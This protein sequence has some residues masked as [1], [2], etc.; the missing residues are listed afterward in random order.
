MDVAAKKVACLDAMKSQGY[1]GGYAR[2]RIETDD[3]AFGNQ[4]ALPYAECFITLYSPT[5]YYLPVSALDLQKSK[6]SDHDTITLRSYR[7]NVP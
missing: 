5:N 7:V 3:G 2:K 4:V 6:L 1:G